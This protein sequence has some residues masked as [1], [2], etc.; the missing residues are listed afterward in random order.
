MKRFDSRPVVRTGRQQPKT[1]RSAQLKQLQDRRV[2]LTRQ[3]TATPSP[4]FI[5]KSKAIT[6]P[7]DWLMFAFPGKAEPFIH[8]LADRILEGDPK[9][10]AQVAR[11]R[12]EMGL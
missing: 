2:E 3:A 12:E 6:D 10:E 7:I 8:R 1:N 11:V 5:A 9:A 4:Q